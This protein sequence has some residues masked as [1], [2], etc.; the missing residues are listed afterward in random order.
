[1]FSPKQSIIKNCY[2]NQLPT[3]IIRHPVTEKDWS[4]SLQTLEGH[5]RTVKAVTFS[6]DDKQLASA[7]SDHT[8]RLW[9]AASGASRGTLE[10]HL[11]PVNAVT[12]SPDGKQ[13]A[14]ASSDHTVQLWDAATGASR[15]TLEGH[16]SWVDAVTFSPNGKQLASASNDHT[17][18]L[19]D[20]AS[21][22]PIKTFY[23]GGVSAVSLSANG[24]YLETNRGPLKL[25][26]TL[27]Y[28]QNHTSPVSP[29]M[30]NGNWLTW[31]HHL[32]LWL[33]VE[34][35]P[36]CSTSRGNLFVMGHSSGQVTFIELAGAVNRSAFI[37]KA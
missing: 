29:W 23:I 28:A 4:S 13:L 35:R 8:V 25:K 14:S 11:G 12:F 2:L 5:S 30:I 6:P 24:S 1:M 10:A 16:S 15:G 3:W 19:W 31:N 26:S 37:T 17:V 20:A 21:G 9:D 32:A 7:S 33:P 34:F 22:R 27:N 36:S 18:R